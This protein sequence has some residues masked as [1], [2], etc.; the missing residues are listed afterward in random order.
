MYPIAL[1]P[2][3][4]NRMDKYRFSMNR[5][6]DEINNIPALNNVNKETTKYI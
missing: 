5:L 1:K 2:I 4:K 6:L 3:N